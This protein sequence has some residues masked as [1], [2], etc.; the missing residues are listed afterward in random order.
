V[1][2]KADHAGAEATLRDLQE[3]YPHVLGTI[4]VNGTGLS[5]AMAAIT[6]HQQ[7]APLTRESPS[8]SAVRGIH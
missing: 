2:N 3:W 8:N 7:A 4:A 5:E 6:A 1:V